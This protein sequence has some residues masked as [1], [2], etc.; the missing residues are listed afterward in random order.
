MIAV[1]LGSFGV[2]SFIFGDRVEQSCRRFLRPILASRS[3]R[4]SAAILRHLT[5][6]VFC[7]ALWLVAT[8]VSVGYWMQ[9]D[10][11]AAPVG[12]QKVFVWIAVIVGAPCMFVGRALSR[13]LGI[14]EESHI[15]WYALAPL[16]VGALSYA[17]VVFT[18]RRITNKASHRTERSGS[19]VRCGDEQ[20][21]RAC[22]GQFV[23]TPRCP[24][25]IA[26]DSAQ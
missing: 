17:L 1:G 18:I 21:R 16:S 14:P 7:S 22:E 12:S 25:S 2:L 20:A 11:R 19:P 3:F 5:G 26:R 6:V 23:T 9:F 10:Y 13:I 4:V 15:L 24:R 8:I